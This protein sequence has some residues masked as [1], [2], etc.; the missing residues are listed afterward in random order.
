M[1]EDIKRIAMK[2]INTELAKRTEANIAQWVADEKPTNNVLLMMLLKQTQ[3]RMPARV[4]LLE[5][6]GIVA[7]VGELLKAI[8]QQ[9]K[10][11]ID[12]PETDARHLFQQDV[13]T[14]LKQVERLQ[15]LTNQ[16]GNIERKE[17]AGQ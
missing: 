3:L 15:Y 16:L 17:E 14:L 5:M 11:Q 10:Q 13:S 7:G 8:K 6:L 4:A 2:R 9:T 1:N 12:N